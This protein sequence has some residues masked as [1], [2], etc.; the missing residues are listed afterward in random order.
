MGWGWVGGRLVRSRLI[1]YI[2]ISSR[3]QGQL[4]LTNS[5]LKCKSV[6]WIGVHQ[7][8][9]CPCDKLYQNPKGTYLFRFVYGCFF[10][11]FFANEVFRFIP[12]LVAKESRII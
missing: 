12:S 11:L 9:S 3:Q 8:D 6:L 1:S 10:S 2:L 5:Q 7:L 4:V